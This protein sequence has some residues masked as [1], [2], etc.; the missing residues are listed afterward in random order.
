MQQASAACDYEKAAQL[1]D[2]REALRT[3][4]EATFTEDDKYDSAD[5]IGIASNERHACIAVTSIRHGIRLGERHYFPNNSKDASD[6]EIIS[7]FLEQ[8]YA[9]DPAHS[10]G[11]LILPCA[12]E[13]SLLAHWR[14]PTLMILPKGI[15][16]KRLAMAQQNAQLSLNQKY[17]T[18]P[19]QQRQQRALAVAL[20]ISSLT[21]IDCFDVS[22]HQGEATRGA[23]VRYRDGVPDKG[24]YRRFSILGKQGE[25]DINDDYYALAETLLR[26]YRKKDATPL[27]DLIII[28][29]GRGQLSR[30][31]EALEQLGIGDIPWIG[32]AKTPSRRGGD[33]TVLASDG[34][35]LAFGKTD[36]AF[37]FL[38]RIRDEAHRFV[39]SSH[40][41]ARDK[42]RRQS[43]LESIHGIGPKKRRLLL[44]HFGSVRRL[45]ETGY[46]QLREIPGISDTLAK[47]ILRQLQS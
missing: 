14:G 38:L 16:A 42:K 47:N 12:P 23:R 9:A 21:R 5:Y 33:E 11:R 17:K 34:R 20:G 22:H 26:C 19:P 15:L 28:D 35:A 24:A 30:A 6:A 39:I 1:R 41:R 13:E 2:R 18:H 36:A 25:A 3:I 27:P 31:G 4:G 40:R 37:L 10:P 29:G 46:E 44:Q 45:R 8:H 32:I 7:A 43:I